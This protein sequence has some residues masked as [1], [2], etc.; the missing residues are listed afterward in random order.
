MLNGF[1]VAVTASAAA[2]ALTVAAEVPDDPYAWLEEI[3]GPKALE[4]TV[5]MRELMGS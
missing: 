2:V 4:Y 3:E 5:F 1:V